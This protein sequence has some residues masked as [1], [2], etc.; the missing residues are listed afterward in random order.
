M[1]NK[2]QNNDEDCGEISER[3]GKL[4]CLV[5]NRANVDYEFQIPNK[6]GLP[7]FQSHKNHIALM[8]EIGLKAQMKS[9]RRN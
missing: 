3:E 9:V 4:N 8:Q 6:F 2:S 1:V 7:V 5:L